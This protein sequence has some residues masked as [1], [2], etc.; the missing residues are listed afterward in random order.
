ML[1][2]VPGAPP[3]SPPGLWVPGAG[4]AGVGAPGAFTWRCPCT[5]GR[6]AVVRREG[7]ATL[8]APAAPSPRGGCAFQAAAWLLASW[9]SAGV[10]CQGNGDHLTHPPRYCYPASPEV[11]G[12]GEE[13]E[14]GGSWPGRKA[15]CREGR[16]ARQPPTEGLGHGG[17]GIR[18]A[19][20][21]GESG[22]VE[23]RAGRMRPYSPVV[24]FSAT[25]WLCLR[26]PLS[27]PS[28]AW[29]RSPVGQ[30][31]PRCKPIAGVPLTIPSCTGGQLGPVRAEL[32]PAQPRVGDSMWPWPCKH[33]AGC[34]CTNCAPCVT[35]WCSTAIQARC[36]LLWGLGSGLWDPA[37]AQTHS[38][39]CPCVCP[40]RPLA[41][42]GARR[43]RGGA[44]GRQGSALYFDILP[45]YF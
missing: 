9:G 38:C 15:G 1:A 11:P 28:P 23:V 12:W 34:E 25:T 36:W 6:Q 4:L 17:V 19:D 20:G 44:L 14:E 30:H 7:A 41:F 32:G 43:W 13:E 22:G 3:V 24:L 18:G 26:C 40:I 39:H 16:G 45:P 21:E 5:R 42:W 27:S 29:A 35:S 10:R 8:P 2:P 31:K 37:A 33:L